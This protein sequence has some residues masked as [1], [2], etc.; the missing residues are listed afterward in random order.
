MNAM[1]D[2]ALDALWKNVL[3]HWDDERAH[4]AFLQ[5][6]QNGDQL[7]EAAVRYRGMTTDRERGEVADR[8][9][10]GVAILAMAKLESA[11]ARPV[12]STPSRVGGLL[13]MAIFILAGAALLLHLRGGILIR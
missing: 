8:R 13:L 12:R 5:H 10:Q 3:D 11:R 7:V 1:V 4:G 6:C 2:P 9:L